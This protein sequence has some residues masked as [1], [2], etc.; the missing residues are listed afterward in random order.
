[1]W[2]KAPLREARGFSKHAERRKS[3]S[4]AH[5][6][7][8]A[9]GGCAAQMWTRDVG[10]VSGTNTQQSRTKASTRVGDTVDWLPFPFRMDGRCR[11][12]TRHGGLTPLLRH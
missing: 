1:M 9:Q 11:G 5:R 6:G 12:R 8:C 10:L 3:V 7:W 4:D 2:R